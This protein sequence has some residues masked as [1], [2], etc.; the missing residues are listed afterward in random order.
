MKANNMTIN[1]TRQYAILPTTK[2][3]MAKRE[4]MI[5]QAVERIQGAKQNSIKFEWQ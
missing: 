1:K 3:D 5:R 2:L 4:E